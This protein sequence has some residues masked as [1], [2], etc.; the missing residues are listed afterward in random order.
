MSQ[1]EA[2]QR[3]ISPESLAKLPEGR[4]TKTAQALA[5]ACASEHIKL[6][7]AAQH[8][9]TG[10]KSSEVSPPPGPKPISRPAAAERRGKLAP[11]SRAF[12]CAQARP[13]HHPQYAT[14]A[15]LP[16][17]TSPRSWKPRATV[18]VTQD[19]PK[20]NLTELQGQ[21][22]QG[23]A[24]HV[25]ADLRKVQGVRIPHQRIFVAQDD[26]GIHVG[27]MLGQALESNLHVLKRPAQGRHRI[28]GFVAKFTCAACPPLT[29]PGDCCTRMRLQQV[30]KVE[31]SQRLV[32][33]ALRVQASAGTTCS[34]V[35]DGWVCQ[36]DS[37]RTPC[38]RECLC[39][40]C[41]V[42]QHQLT[43]A[44]NTYPVTATLTYRMPRCKG[45]AYDL[46][47]PPRQLQRHAEKIPRQTC[48]TV[49]AV[50]GD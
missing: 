13:D 30:L 9:C 46:S 12:A 48:G 3:A 50:L 10:T 44:S 49:G 29:V 21:L 19:N 40:G 16:E 35:P 2:R 41:S 31:P 6:P 42:Y 7:S 4:H 18:V 23:L 20:P 1:T 33:H 45:Y 17:A 27:Q 22:G 14:S 25:R 15:S 26:A 24:E 5:W 43:S 34:R 8:R 36:H 47:Y 32:F 39:M 37:R 38:K 28:C 11:S